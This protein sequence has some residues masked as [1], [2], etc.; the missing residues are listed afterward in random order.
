MIV[1]AELKVCYK[2]F[3]AKPEDGYKI[4]PA[5]NGQLKITPA[6]DV[7]KY[8]FQ[9]VMKEAHDSVQVILNDVELVELFCLDEKDEGVN[10]YV[11]KKIEARK[12]LGFNLGVIQLSLKSDATYCPLKT[13]EN[14]DALIKPEELA[15]M[16]E[17]VARSEFFNLFISNYTRANTLGAESESNKKHFWLIIFTAK[18]LLEEM[19]R[20]VSGELLLTSRVKT[21][22][23][24][25]K[26]NTLSTIENNDIDW[27]LTHPDELRRSNNGCV[28]IN[29]IGYDLEYMSQSVTQESYDTYENRLLV[30]VLFSIKTTLVAI[31]DEHASSKYFPHTAL[32]EIIKQ[33]NE[34]IAELNKVL[35]LSPPFNTYP[36]YSNKFLGD[37][38]YLKLFN[39]ISRWYKFNNLDIGGEIRAPT[40]EITAVFEHF[41][42]VKIVE[43]IKLLGFK[44]EDKRFKDNDQVGEAVFRKGEQKILIYYE[45]KIGNDE[46]LPV[47]ASKNNNVGF[48]P[49]F[50][51]IYEYGDY[52]KYGVIDPKFTDK[53]S[54]KKLAEQ[55]HYKYGLFLHGKDWRPLDYVFAIYPA[56]QGDFEINNARISEFPAALAPSLGYFS[57]Q[58]ENKV[59]PELSDFLGE[60]ITSKPKARNKEFGLST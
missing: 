1:S 57:I 49:D 26:Y 10:I 31:C 32:N 15:Y 7:D 58:L 42:F 9:V 38:R 22:S 30:T 25:S 52:V 59:S 16:Y 6:F 53:K 12:F 33:S 41:C 28:N 18:K 47:K 36:E 3:S 39:L 43:A 24:I 37:N 46:R 17:S 54:I 23:E 13:I 34:L 51:L 56:K 44:I 35:E 50:T 29:G 19:A 21:T 2:K 11:S 20:F 8:Y 27:L 55:I 4:W 5:T 45:L 14:S 40:L 48:L 60:L